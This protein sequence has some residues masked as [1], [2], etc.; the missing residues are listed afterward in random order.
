MNLLFSIIAITGCLLA[1]LAGAA[2]LRARQELKQLKESESL[3]SSTFDQASVGMVHVRMSDG[4]FVRANPKICDWLGYTASEFCA[5]TILDVTH[6]EDMEMDFSNT[7]KMV[8]G[9][10]SKFT[11]EKRLL[12]KDGSTAW[13]RLTA[14]SVARNDAGVATYGM[15]VVEDISYLRETEQSLWES[16]ERFKLMADAAPVFI[17]LTNDKPS[18]IYANKTCLDYTGLTNTKDIDWEALVHP[19]DIDSFITQFTLRFQKRENF[20]AEARLKHTDGNYHWILLTAVPRYTPNQLFLGYIG[21]GIDINERKKIEELLVLAKK[22]AESANKKK[23][24]FLSLMSHELRTPL[25]AINGFSELLKIGINGELN[26]KQAEYIEYVLSSGHHLL[27]IVNDLL[28]VS[29]IEAGKMKLIVEP[30]D[31]SAIIHELMPLIEELAGK[32]SI[33]FHY[34]VSPEVSMFNADKKRIKQI[35]INL[36]SNAIKFNKP[37]GS[38]FVHICKQES[39][40]AIQFSVKDTGIGIEASKLDQLFQKFYQVD[41]LG[42]HQQEGTGLGLALTK[43]LIEMHGGN[44]EVVTEPGVG[45]L[46]TFIIPSRICPEHAALLIGSNYSD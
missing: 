16:E 25:H 37:G 8:M 35:L 18:L 34:V 45:S 4:K 23:S 28:D 15:A 7:Q 21:T 11:I 33:R 40:E 10:V 30:N 39:P 17:F 5:K 3:F 44:I 13:A 32:N 19:D 46:F 31:P 6:P 1:T 20:E 29:K 14:A 42:E 43:D 36:I 2:L 38:V 9:E 41:E 26:D 27:N 22:Q 24:E 12:K